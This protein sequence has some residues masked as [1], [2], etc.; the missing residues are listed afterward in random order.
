MRSCVIRAHAAIHCSKP[1]R[2]IRLTN[3]DKYSIMYRHYKNEVE[4]LGY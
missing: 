3:R 1:L 4:N 2:N